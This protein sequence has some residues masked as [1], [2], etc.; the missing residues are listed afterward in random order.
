MNLL[1]LSEL[2]SIL[3]FA[4]SWEQKKMS[5]RDVLKILPAKIED[6]AFLSVVLMEY[7]SITS[8]SV[9]SKNSPRGIRI[10]FNFQ[11]FLIYIYI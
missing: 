3:H 1:N 7:L 10:T 4:L 5:E 8:S 6:N 11:F 9:L 2:L